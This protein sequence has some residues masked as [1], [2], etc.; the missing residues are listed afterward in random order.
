MTHNLM[1]EWA[2]K[3]NGV[4][5]R[6]N[7][8]LGICDELR[9]AAE[10]EKKDEM[11]RAKQPG[12][13]ALSFRIQEEEAQR[14]AEIVRL[15]GPAMDDSTAPFVAPPRPTVDDMAEDETD[16]EYLARISA[17]PVPPVRDHATVNDDGD[18]MGE[19]DDGVMIDDD[20]FYVRPDIEDDELIELPNDSSYL[21]D[22]FW[23][24]FCGDPKQPSA[25]AP[26]YNTSARDEDDEEI[27]FQGEAIKREPNT[28]GDQAEIVGSSEQEGRERSPEP[29]F[30]GPSQLILWRDKESQIADD[31]LKTMG[32]KLR[33]GRAHKWKAFDQEARKGG[34]FDGKKIHPKVKTLKPAV[35]ATG[36]AEDIEDAVMS[37]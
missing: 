18:E 30:A 15:Y 8:C 4:V 9:R 14:R 23:S 34:R 24:S 3:Y 37:G 25:Q 32:I 5:G 10:Q 19:A 28:Q 27:C 33:V 20:N 6:S 36:E 31:V 1:V 7:Y 13:R 16:D 21:A 35:A 12:A 2:R 29:S 26:S 11:E 17:P 22:L